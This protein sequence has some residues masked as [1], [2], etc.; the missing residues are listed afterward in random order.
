MGFYARGELKAISFP[1]IISLKS[2][3]P[4]REFLSYSDTQNFEG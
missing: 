4:L 2:P 3:Q 1:G